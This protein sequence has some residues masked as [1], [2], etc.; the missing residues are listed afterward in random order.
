MNETIK[1]VS[2]YKAKKPRDQR[3]ARAKEA[4]GRQIW[5][6][7][8]HH[9]DDL[10]KLGIIAKESASSITRMVLLQHLTELEGEG[11]KRY[12]M[13]VARFEK[14]CTTTRRNTKSPSYERAFGTDQELERHERAGTT[15]DYEEAARHCK[16][17]YARLMKALAP[18]GAQGKSLLDD[19]CCSDVEPPA[20]T[21]ANVAIMLRQVVK[22]FGVTERP[23]S[24]RRQ[25]RR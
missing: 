9:G 12:A 22:A 13:V 1:N 11:A 17:E 3:P 18:Y 25:G 19:L 21:R 14:F 16:K 8:Q 6:T 20:Q 15:A 24:N 10:I 5:K 23:R 4:R 2:A 7:L